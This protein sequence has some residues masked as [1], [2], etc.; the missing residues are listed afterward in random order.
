ML[1][2]R[3]ISPVIAAHPV[4]PFEWACSSEAGPGA[5]AKHLANGDGVMFV[6]LTNGIVTHAF[7]VFPATRED[8]LENVEEVKAAKRAEFNEAARILGLTDWRVLDFPESP[9]LLGLDPRLPPGRGAAS[10][11]GGDRATGSYGRR[12]VYVGGG[13]LCSS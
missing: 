1:R 9:M 12:P 3:M 4:D 7:G 11:S 10:P 6:S 8:K 2:S 13:G 5:A